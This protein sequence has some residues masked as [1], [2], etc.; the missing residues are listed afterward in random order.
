MTDVW[1]SLRDARLALVKTARQL[2]P[3]Q[4]DARSWCDGWRVR[5]VLGH[6]VHLAEATQA[7]MARDVLTHGLVPERALSQVATGLGTLHPNELLSRLEAAAGGRFHVIGSPA[8]VTVGEAITHGADMLRPLGVVL[9]TDPAIVASVLPVYVRVRRLVF[10][11]SSLGSVRLVATDA[12]WAFGSGAE[13][14]GR[15]VDLL[16]VLANRRQAVGDLS[17]PGLPALTLALPT[18]ER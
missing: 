12:D 15:A 17:G 16:L 3:A 18:P 11:G 9:E 13:V 7:S 6:L 14:T 5:D 10:H 4:W 8:V 2:E 1:A